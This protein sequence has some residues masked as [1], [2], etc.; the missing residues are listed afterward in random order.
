[1][2]KNFIIIF[3]VICFITSCKTIN[4]SQ[5]SQTNTSQQVSLGTIGSNK[6]FLLQNKFNSAAIPT[7]KAPIKLSINIV[8]FNKQTHKAF[9]K[10]KAL[11]AANVTIN[12]I[13]TIPNKPKY[14]KLQIADKVAIIKALNSEENNGVKDYLS[15]N[16]YANVLT[17]ISLA[18]NK[19]KLKDVTKADAAFL[20]EKRP[21]TYTLQ[22]YKN[23]TKT[24]I[25]LNQGVVFAYKSS[26]CCWQENKK[27]RLNIVDLVSEFNSCPNK[28]YRSAKRARKKINYYKL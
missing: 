10:A 11:Q 12:Y 13:D 23:A 1:M 8:S 2:L 4:I 16:T 7:Y 17:S 3:C 27:Y 9:I 18:L 5:E 24:E 15:H 26:N 25:S 22:L 14:V 28:T 21:K 6:D 19:D 20:I